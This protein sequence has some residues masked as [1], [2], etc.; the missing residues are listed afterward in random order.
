MAEVYVP[1]SVNLSFETIDRES[2][3]AQ[4]R[5]L[6][7]GTVFLAISEYTEAADICPNI[8]AYK[9]FLEK[10]GFRTG[11]WFGGSLLHFHYGRRFR[12]TVLA[13]GSRSKLICPFDARFVAFYADYVKQFVPTGIRLFLLDDDFRLHWTHEAAC[14]CPHHLREYSRRLGKKVTR[15]EMA[16]AILNGGPSEYRSAW[17]QVNGEALKSFARAIRA[18]VD[19]AD[20][21]VNIGL[22][23]GGSNLGNDGVG[24]EELAEIL[25]GGHKPFLRLHGAPYWAA[26]NPARPVPYC[27]EEERLLASLCKEGTVRISEGDTWP[28]PRLKCPAAYLEGFDAAL[29]AEEKLDGILKYGCDYYAGY[30]YE[31]GYADAAE[32]NR[33]FCAEIEKMFRSKEPCGF[34]LAEDLFCLEKAHFDSDASRAGV[35]GESVF[36]SLLFC[37][38]HSM[39]CCYGKF[40][41]PTVVFGCNA[42]AFLNVLRFQNGV[43]LDASA[44]MILRDAGIDVGLRGEPVPIQDGADA[45][46]T[47]TKREYF[48]NC[49][50]EV[51]ISFDDV[52]SFTV[53]ARADVLTQIRCGKEVC[54]GAYY[55]ENAE[56]G[57]FY[58]LPYAMRG[59]RFPVSAFVSYYRQRELADVYRRMTGQE[60]PAACFGNPGLYTLVKRE[61]N[62]VAVFLWNYCADPIETPVVQMESAVREIIPLRC[63]AAAQGRTVSLTRMEPFAMCAFEARLCE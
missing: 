19:E 11:L 43:V 13:D 21:S 10:E 22:C 45:V 40:G 51:G 42:Y 60:L 14:F 38:Q 33:G 6:G 1:I 50:A 15:K 57:R 5:K 25:S 54:T 31:T 39:P 37:T 52:Y 56:G 20:P 53:D 12:Q 17:L 3:L 62:R 44:A 49:R 16:S 23:A 41:Q 35:V 24:A 47:S 59:T 46:C 32:K 61:K 58:V 8:V 36:S 2:L 29:R 4:L 34:N 9:N 28:R 63:G 18:A 27:I 55:Y 48:I 7:A 26:S 30:A